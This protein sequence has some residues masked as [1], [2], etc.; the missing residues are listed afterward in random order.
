MVGRPPAAPPTP[1]RRL[2]REETLTNPS[3]DELSATLRQQRKAAGLSGIEAAQRAGFSQPKISRFETG[4]QAPTPDEVA[5][6]AR[7]YRMPS[8]TRA[9]L[10]E[11]AEAL[12]ASTSRSRAVLSHGAH[13]MQQRLARIEEASSTIRSFVPTMVTGL[14]QTSEYARA[15]GSRDMSGHALDAFVAARLARQ[16]I[17]DT[18][19]YI[20]AIIT[21]GGLRWHVG[22]PTTMADQ[23]DH[24]IDESHRRNLELGVIPWTQPV[25]SAS[26]HCFTVYDSRAVT[27]GTETSTAVI[28]DAADVRDYG[29]RHDLFA[30]YAAYGD[31]ARAELRR[32]ADE[33]RRL[34]QV[35]GDDS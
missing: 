8:E 21:E 15:I 4:R 23:L 16:Q 20:R 2:N 25:C 6:L 22:S 5:T 29:Q 17:L 9:R 19:R 13:H 11:L 24:L 7:V 28:T 26:L 35:E 34:E 30:Q 32:I 31:D 10:L 18:P 33:Y 12:R 14:L 27:V 1:L 3:P